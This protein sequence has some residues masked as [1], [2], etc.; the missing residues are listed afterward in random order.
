[1]KNNIIDLPDVK[2]SVA[3]LIPRK[4]N[5]IGSDYVN[6]GLVYEEIPPE[7]ADILYDVD[8]KPASIQYNFLPI[9]LLKEVQRMA[10]ELK[11]LQDKVEILNY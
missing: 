8:G 11:S 10:L 5:C 4:F 9:I 7:L 1:M 2:D 3:K 6:Y